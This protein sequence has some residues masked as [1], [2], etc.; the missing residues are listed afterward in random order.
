VRFGEVGKEHAEFFG[1]SILG[2]LDIVCVRTASTWEPI[3]WRS[4][5]GLLTY[6]YSLQQ[7][8]DELVVLRQC[9]DNL[10]I[11]GKVDENGDGI[12]GDGL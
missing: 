6:C 4:K 12:L 5:V 1:G 9:L 10:L 8:F 11:M 2:I 7:R 3:R